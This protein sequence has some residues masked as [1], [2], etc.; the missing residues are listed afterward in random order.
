MK[1]FWLVALV[2]GLCGCDSANREARK[3]MLSAVASVKIHATGGTLAE[4]SAS[5]QQVDILLAA[6]PEAF[7]AIEMER[8]LTLESACSVL[9]TEYELYPRIPLRGIPS[10]VTA[11]ELVNPGVALE[12]SGSA[13]ES[14]ARRRTNSFYRP[15]IQAVRAANLVAAECD[16]L[17]PLLR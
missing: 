7:R 16:R 17:L 4:F 10:I 1:A 5:R 11:L 6:H 8:L 13:D 3:E 2:L 15:A 12:F 14:Y 9:W